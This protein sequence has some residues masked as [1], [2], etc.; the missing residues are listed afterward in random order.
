M[1]AHAHDLLEGTKERDLIVRPTQVHA[2][3][4]E[5][6]KEKYGYKWKPS[7]HMPKAACRIWLRVKSVTIERLQSITQEDAI[8]EGVFFSDPYEGYVTDSEGRSFHTF[9]PARSFEHLWC[10][11]NGAE[12]WDANPW[13]WV[14]EFEKLDQMPEGFLP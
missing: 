2:D 13:V 1:A 6:A 11:I 10:S 3:W 7:I 5:Y 9:L 8:K 4:M 12:S 14:I